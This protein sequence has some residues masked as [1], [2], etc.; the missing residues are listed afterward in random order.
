MPLPAHASHA[1]HVSGSQFTERVKRTRRNHECWLTFPTFV[2]CGL[3]CLAAHSAEPSSTDEQVPGGVQPTPAQTRTG[4]GRVFARGCSSN[5]CANVNG[6][7][8][9]VQAERPLY[10]WNANGIQQAF[11]QLAICDG[12]G[13]SPGPVRVLSD[14]PSPGV[15]GGKRSCAGR[16]ARPAPPSAGRCRRTG[17]RCSRFDGRS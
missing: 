14:Q 16:L 9:P 12:P 2:L 3:G 6:F 7:L 5:I 11:A 8:E 15:E 1:L 17:F 10:C 13:I 4:S